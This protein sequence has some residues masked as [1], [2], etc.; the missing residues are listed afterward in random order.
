MHITK[1]YSGVAFDIYAL[2][3]RKICQV[4]KYI[5]S[6]DKINQGQIFAL[7]DDI[8]EN[9]PP[10]NIQKFKYIKDGIYELKTWRGVRIL[11]F[12]GN[13][14]LPRSLILTHGFPKP[15]PKQLNNEKA[16]A[17]KWREKYLK[18]DDIRKII[19]LEGKS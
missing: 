2:V 4:R 13:P 16:K 7:F 11:S 14:M 5:S 15:K 10:H 9:G 19:D 17:V 1:L 12:Y 8:L 18:I 3:I 6:L